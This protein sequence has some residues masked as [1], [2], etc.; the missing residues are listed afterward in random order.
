MSAVMNKLRNAGT[1]FQPGTFLY[2]ALFGAALGVGLAGG[3]YAGRVIRVTFF[4][5][6]HFRVQSRQRYLEKQYIF[7]K[8]LQNSQ[9]A[10]ALASLVQEYDPV[11]TR[12]PFQKIE[13]KYRF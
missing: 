3:A 12:L 7:F 4:D 8:E 11:D 6:E 2:S 13:D 5:E 1:Y 10:H 9:K